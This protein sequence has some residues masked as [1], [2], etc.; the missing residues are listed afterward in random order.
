M[1]DRDDISAEIA[2]KASA[3]INLA[4]QH[5]E[6]SKRFTAYDQFRSWLDYQIEVINEQWDQD[7]VDE[8]QL[9]Y[10]RGTKH[11]IQLVKEHL[12]QYFRVH[13]A[14]ASE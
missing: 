14:P 7:G 4:V 3:H 5:Q 12:D 2:A 1:K 13:I 10:L 11:G 6:M 8:M 9:S